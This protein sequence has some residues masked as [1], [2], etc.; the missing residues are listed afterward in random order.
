MQFG[1][2]QPYPEQPRSGS[3]PA[4]VSLVTAL[5]EILVGV[6][7]QDRQL[8]ERILVVPQVSARDEDLAEAIATQVPE[9]FD[10]LVVDGLVLK[11]TTLR[12]RTALELLTSG[13]LLAPPLTATRQLESR[14]VSRYL[15]HGRVTLAAIEFRFREAA[16]HWPG[17]ADFLHDRLGQQTHRA[18]MHLA[19]MHLPRVEDRVMALF[20]DLAERYGRVTPQGVLIELRLTHEIIGAL[21]GS[22]R[23]TVSLALRTL[24]SQGMLE[25]RTDG[26]WMLTRSSEAALPQ[27]GFKLS[28]PPDL[29]SRR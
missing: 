3:S 23:P 20:S 6:P 29:V 15:A 5:P 25:R 21:V 24:A 10:L 14:A 28:R 26:W 7:A 11:E 16:R 19:M 17:L 27:V 2:R 1:A 12:G 9:A 13:D 4:T 22:R 8:A 18:S